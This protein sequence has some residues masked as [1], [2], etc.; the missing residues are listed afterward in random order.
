V[1]KDVPPPLD[2]ICRKA[3][4]LNP[5]DRYGSALEL[6]ADVE[7]WLADEPVSAYR[8]PWTTR[9]GRWMRRHKPVVASARM[10][11][12]VAVLLG[13]AGAVGLARLRA[14]RRAEQAQQDKELRQGVEAALEKV[15]DLQRQARW[16]E[17]RA[18]LDQALDR[19]GPAGP[20]DLR[21]RG[22]QART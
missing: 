17:A 13:S 5:D 6:A 15:T 16:D 2:A 14:E 11:V 3:M 10:A 8:E 1:K 12:L 21:Q 4:A 9:W 18:V 7:H 19:L 22:E 20:Q